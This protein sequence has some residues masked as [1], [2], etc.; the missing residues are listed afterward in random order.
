MTPEK[1]KE[2]LDKHKL[3]LEGA[4]GGQR[5]S[6]RNANLRRANFENSNLEGADLRG[7][8]DIWRAKVNMSKIKSISGDSE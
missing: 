3:W 1:I 7:A 5:A 2:I 8:V 6:F 4:E